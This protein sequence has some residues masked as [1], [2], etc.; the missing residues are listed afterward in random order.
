[1]FEGMEVWT[2]LDTCASHSYI[3]LDLLSL[4]P[5]DCIIDTRVANETVTLADE[6]QV[7]VMKVVY[8]QF[9]IEQSEVR[10]E[11]TAL[12]SLSHDIIIGRDLLMK[13]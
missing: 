1:M 2:A 11:F 13:L 12:A 7:E 3:S 6:S 4:L 8:L 5:N 10:H 9:V